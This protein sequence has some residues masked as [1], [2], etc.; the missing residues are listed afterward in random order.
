M[1]FYILLIDFGVDGWE[2]SLEGLEASGGNILAKELFNIHFFLCKVN[3]SL[4]GVA[5]AVVGA[6]QGFS[7]LIYSIV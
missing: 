6:L 3:T 1:F 4:L 7:L 5:W 2:H